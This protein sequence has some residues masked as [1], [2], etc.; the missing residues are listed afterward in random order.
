MP[1]VAWALEACE[2]SKWFGER[3]VLR[4]VSLQ[5]AAGQ[6]MALLGPNGSGKTTLLGVLAGV[7]RADH[8]SALCHGASIAS[9]RARRELGFVPQSAAVYDE[10]TGAENAAL[11]ARLSGLRG[12]RLRERVEASLRA[13]ELWS[14]RDQRARTFSGGMRRRLSLACALVHEPSVLLLDEPFEGV[15][16]DSRSH[17]L[18]VLTVSKRRGTALLLSTH[19]LEDVTALCEQFS[20]LR[21]GALMATRSVPESDLARET[22][23]P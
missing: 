8:G 19:R 20:L 5:L 17:L 12:T 6:G 9:K 1:E 16:E 10:L 2:L 4:D 13:A 18:D 7:L 22:P 14:C 11:F 15:D 3:R 21:D 23:L